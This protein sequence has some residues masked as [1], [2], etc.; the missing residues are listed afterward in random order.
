VVGGLVD[1][2]VDAL[3][4]QGAEVNVVRLRDLAI[5]GCT[6][7]LACRVEGQCPRRDDTW[8]LARSLFTAD[9][10]VI[11]TPSA[12]GSPDRC[13]EALLDRIEGALVTRLGD[14]LH[15]VRAD[16]P[17]PLAV[18][19]TAT[20]APR[21]VA[22]ALGLV[23]KPVAR[24]RGGLTAIGVRTVG[25]MAL[26]DTWRRPK[27]TKRTRRQAADLARRLARN[28]DERANLHVARHPDHR[29]RAIA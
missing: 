29:A 17:G 27:L 21:S 5:A 16:H 13:V 6:G 8:S 26:T 1:V 23:S 15:D 24:V 12:W 28:V 14:S 22:S 9:G 2:A 3:E 4:A 10:V 19:M 25:A 18:V 20:K 7:C 11:G